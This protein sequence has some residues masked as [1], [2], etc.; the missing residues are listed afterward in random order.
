MT[1]AAIVVIAVKIAF[2]LAFMLLLAAVAPWADRRQ[3][4][5]VQD[6]IG[7]ERAVLYLPAWLVSA[8]LFLP[9]AVA[10][11]AL[12]MV[13]MGAPAGPAEVVAGRL[14]ERITGALELAILVCWLSLMVLA[15][16]V[17][18]RG[19]V[20]GFEQAVGRLD[21]RHYFYAGLVLHLLCLPVARALPEPALRAGAQ[22]AGIIAGIA[23]MASGLYAASKVPAGKVGVRLLGLLHVVADVVKLLFKEDLRPKGSDRLLHALGPLL[24]LFAPLLTIA[25]VP[26]GSTLCFKDNGNRVL[27]F[28]DLAQLAGD[29]GRSGTCRAGYHSVHLQV[30]ELN[31][32]LLFIFA[33]AGTGIIGAA[34]AGWASDNKFSLLGGLRATSQMVSYE[35]ALGL[36]AVGPL[37]VYGSVQLRAIVDW[38]GSHAW[39]IFVQPLAFLLFFAAS[40]AETRRVPFD[41]PEGESEIVAGYVLE[42]SGMKFGMFFLGEY[43]EFIFSSVL[44]VTLFL[45]GY[46]LPFLGPGGLDVA[47]GT[48]SLLHLPMSHLAVSLLHVAAF[49]GK[50]V[51]VTWFLVFIRWTLPRF[52]YDQLMALG[53]KTLLPLGLGNILLTGLVV[54]A[55]ASGGKDVDA[56][57]QTAG[58]VTQALV[59]LGALV[60]LVILITW[61]LEPPRYGRFVQSSS[62]RQAASSGGVETAAR[63]VGRD[64]GFRPRPGSSR[65]GVRCGPGLRARSRSRPPD[66]PG[67]GM[68]ERLLAKG[69][70]LDG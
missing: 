59:A 23:M 25:V 24:A 18:R 58:D 29:V 56:V 4:A 11:G 65:T 15:A 8:L 48:T 41:L 46:H 67:V 70:R 35:V 28:A 3:S 47:I 7:P 44:L 60:A 45:G 22:A 27:D 40:V 26:F 50:V 49:A 19:A 38:Q 1:S 9:A 34:V 37:V 5:M 10:A 53:W 33:V 39:G 57:L 6:R 31:V 61:L 54:L 55:L 14:V 20:N 63:R 64:R 42:Y 43:L 13:L 36:A 12:I 30:A 66:E 32:G 21:P 16:H 52:R 62:A 51:F 68:R 2:V 69:A 17:R